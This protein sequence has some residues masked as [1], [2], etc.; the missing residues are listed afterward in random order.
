MID[1]NDIVYSYYIN[2]FPDIYKSDKKLYVHHQGS[3]TKKE[4]LYDKSKL[5]FKLFFDKAKKLCGINNKFDGIKNNEIENWEYY[6][7][8]N[9]ELSI[10]QWK[11]YPTAITPYSEIEHWYKDGSYIQYKEQYLV[12]LL[13]KVK[14][15][16]FPW[17]RL[18]RI[19]R[20]IPNSYIIHSEDTPNMRQQ[21]C[22]IM[23]KENLSC[24][25][26][27]CRECKNSSWNTNII[28]VIRQYQKSINN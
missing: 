25:C 13:L 2:D 4:S 3:E 18:N 20:D 6:D 9:P 11:I 24:K 5:L 19:I 14:S 28:L 27:R 7:L 17:I 10:D 1:G 23:K 8:S 26:I 15:I 22:D 12:D 16:M 21:L